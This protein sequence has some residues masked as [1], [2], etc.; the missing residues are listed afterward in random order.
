MFFLKKTRISV[1]DSTCLF[2]SYSRTPD[3]SRPK[4]AVLSRAVFYVASTAR[5]ENEKQFSSD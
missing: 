2:N 3:T 4:Y 5:T 1:S